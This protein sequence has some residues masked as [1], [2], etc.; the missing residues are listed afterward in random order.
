MQC[1]LINICLSHAQLKLILSNII[2]ISRVCLTFPFSLVQAERH[3]PG[4][5]A[6][7]LM[8]C[9]IQTKCALHLRSG[10]LQTLRHRL[11]YYWDT[12]TCCKGSMVLHNN[13]NLRPAWGH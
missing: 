12:G 2:K 9:L 3:H 8:L 13:V 6:A 4:L 11:N 1:N 10:S 5:A 7:L